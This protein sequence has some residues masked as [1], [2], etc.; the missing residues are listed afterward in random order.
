M[1]VAGRLLLGAAVAGLFAQMVALVGNPTAAVAA[2]TATLSVDASSVTGT[3]NTTLTTQIV[4]PTIGGTP[5]AQS[6]LN[7]LAPQ[8]V[9]IHA[10]TDGGFDNVVLPFNVAGKVLEGGGTKQPWDFAMMDSMVNSVR[11]AGTIPVMN[12]RYAPDPMYTCTGNFGDPGV[13]RDQTYGV[14]SDYMENLVR[15][16]NL[17]S[18]TMPQGG[19]KTNPAGTSNRI[20]WWEIWNEPDYPWENPCTGDGTNPIVN[21]TQYVAL[22]NVTATKMKAVD[23]TIKLVGPAPSNHPSLVSGTLHDA[24]D[25]IPT[26]LRNATI[27]P[28]AISFHG[29][30][31]WDNTQSDRLLF[32]GSGGG[33]IKADIDGLADIKSWIA[34]YAPGTPVWLTETNLSAD[35]GLDPAQRAW[36]QFSAAWGA[37]LFRAMVVGGLSVIHQFQFLESKELGLI[38]DTTGTPLLPYWRDYYLSRYFPVGSPILQSTPS[39]LAPEVEILA[40]RQPGGSNVRVLV[41]DRQVGTTKAVGLPV[42]VTLNLQNFAGLQSVNMRMLDAGT[43]TS[44]AT[45]PALVAMPASATQTITFGGYGA[46]LL[47]FSTNVGPTATPTPTPTPTPTAGPSPAPTVTSV[48]PNTGSTLGGTLVTVQGTNF[49]TGATVS[50]GG[51]ALT[52]STVSATSITGTTTAHAAGAVNV[53]VTNVDAQAGTCTSC[54]AY[55]RRPRPRSAR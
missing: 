18:F 10:G 35:P 54:F 15:Y 43:L 32:D 37:S 1:G 30:G 14:F 12:V 39:A 47:E 50:F 23:P 44:L 31:G 42:T 38:D 3:V 45:G 51:S 9:R 49:R 41:I 25:Y 28:D 40:A 6:R 33:G 5:N 26:L 36:N 21:P 27:K 8:M 29:Y 22:W 4:W 46:A 16:Y 55:V 24:N 13:L 53:V 11:A 34:Q 48:T 17:G 52:V 2:T 7:T 19:T 20:T